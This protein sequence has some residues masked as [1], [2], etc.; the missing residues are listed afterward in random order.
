VP[1]SVLRCIMFIAT[2]S[3]DAEIAATT[4]MIALGFFFLL[5]PGEY[6][7]SSGTTDS[8]PFLMQDTALFQGERKLD[9]NT[10]TDGELLAAT[11]GTIKF[12]TEKNS[13]RGEVMG[14]ATS[15]DLLLCPCRALAQHIIYLRRNNAPLT[16]LLARYYL[17]NNP[18]SI[19]QQRSQLP[20]VHQPPTWG[21]A[22]AFYLRTCMLAACQLQERMPFCLPKSIQTSFASLC[23]GDLMKCSATSTSK[24]NL[25]LE[26]FQD[27]C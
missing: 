20:F 9:H 26:P 3:D 10:C 22:S 5:R 8:D 6:C 25:P 15:G 11:F 24:Q 27:K 7:I 19:T 18:C 17:N 21:L 23:A 12:T 13:F 16:T 1:V 4:N 2:A 14:L